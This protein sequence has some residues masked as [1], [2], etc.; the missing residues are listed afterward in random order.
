MSKK[1]TVLVVE[2]N[3]EPRAVVINQTLE[4]MQKIVGGNIE[5]VYPFDEAVALVCNEEGKNEGLPPNRSLCD[6]DGN[7]LDII[8]GTFFICDAAGE[9]FASLTEEQ[10]AKYTAMFKTAEK[11]VFRINGEFILIANACVDGE[12]ECDPHI[13]NAV[14]APKHVTA[15][16][17]F[18][19]ENIEDVF[20]DAPITYELQ[21]TTLEKA[22][23]DLE[24][25]LWQAVEIEGF[26]GSTVSVEVVYEQDGEYLDKDEFFIS[27]VVVYTNEPSEFIVWGDKKPHIFK[28]DRAQSKLSISETCGDAD[29]EG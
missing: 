16:I 23:A 8:V 29:K 25:V 18:V 3:K 22:K 20:A 15:T 21:D 27:P 1:I 24:S 11:S 9:E 13:P 14:K 4:S 2:P 19:Q 6:K 28:I 17:D 5:A 12:K 26:D 7:I 10:T